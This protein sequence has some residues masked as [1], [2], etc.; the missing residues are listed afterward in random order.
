MCRTPDSVDERYH[1]SGN[2]A[3]RG[4]LHRGR[5]GL[6]ESV[7]NLLED[8]NR[9]ITANKCEN[10]KYGFGVGDI[11]GTGGRRGLR[12][13]QIE[14]LEPLRLELLKAANAFI[15]II[16]T[17]PDPDRPATLLEVLKAFEHNVY[18]AGYVDRL[19]TYAKS[20]DEALAEIEKLRKCG[21]TKP[22]SVAPTPTTTD[23]KCNFGDFLQQLIL[24]QERGRSVPEFETV[25]AQLP[26]GLDLSEAE[27]VA[28]LSQFKCE[29]TSRPSQI[30]NSFDPNDKIA[31]MGFGVQGFVRDHVLSF[32][33]Q[34]ENDPNLGATIPAQEVFVTDPLDDD[35]DLTTVEFGTFGFNNFEF[36]VPPGLSH[37]ETTI[38]LRPDGI[39]LLVPVVLDVDRQ[40]GV[41]SATFRS[42]DPSTG[43]LPDDI[44]AG[45]L[46]VNDKQ[47][48]NGEGFF[49]YRV[50]PLATATTGTE[51]RN[52]AS[53]VFDV[54]D[55]ILTPE[56]VHT[57]DLVAPASLVSGLPE[58]FGTAD[59]MVDWSGQ[60]DSGGSGIASYDIF[61]SRDGGPFEPMLT[62]TNETSHEFTGESGSTYAFI[63]LARD[64]V[65]HLEP[66][67]AVADTQTLVIIGAWVNR[68]DIFDVDGSGEVTALDALVIINEM[69]RHR[70]SDPESFVLTPLP[71]DGFAPPYYDVTEDGL[72]T[73]LDALRVINQLARI[74]LGAG[75][76]V[77]EST[78]AVSLAAMAKSESSLSVADTGIDALVLESVRQ[79]RGAL[80]DTSTPPTDSSPVSLP[81]A[82]LSDADEDREFDATLRTLADDV[83]RQWA[84]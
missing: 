75:E 4:V 44:D 40:T 32:E 84:F 80:V 42:L 38:D 49:T 35:L 3:R 79:D 25:L 23:P 37:Y 12:R 41:L 70:V 26:P 64:N 72:V 39:E 55:P 36:D 5:T 27:F 74:R 83:A 22:E 29:A 68:V 60:D 46:P 20:V 10:P 82:P 59:F 69:G 9:F 52:Q 57:I 7:N 54:N 18:D 53:I 2:N 17:S 65:G 71:P 63:S 61:V 51:I 77:G 24:Q 73:A 47:L 1:R 66:M 15:P 78:Q 34:F 33:I 6:Q 67:P 48:H 31:A 62:G 8:L 43:L 16:K 81:S 56:T 28:M 19:R 58:A 30:A 45:F 21:E 11:I 76:S 13:D 14:T 50:Q